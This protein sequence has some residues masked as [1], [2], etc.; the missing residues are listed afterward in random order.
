MPRV[1]I[2]GF[3][4]SAIATRPFARLVALLE[5]FDR[6]RLDLLPVLTYHR[7]DERAGDGGVGSGVFSAT[8][9]EFS[10]Q[11]AWLAVHRRI[12]S[13]SELLDVRRGRT[14][15]P[16]RSI[17]VTFDD[18]YRD[19]ADAA[20]PVLKERGVPVTL[21]VPTA[22]PGFDG[23][24]FWWDKLH[25]A[26]A[27]TARRDEIET[28]FGRLPLRTTDD[29]A[30]ALRAVRTRIRAMAH[31]AALKMLDDIVAQLGVSPAVSPVL[32][33]PE[34]RILAG[35]GV[36]LA[37]HSRTHP[38]LDRVGH[39]VARAEIAGSLCD[40]EREV[41]SAPRVFAYPGG[42][43]TAEV[44]SLV[45]EAG[46]E[47]AFTTQRGMNDLRR[48]DWLRL[49]RINVGRRSTVPLMR[50]QLLSWSRHLSGADGGRP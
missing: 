16:R 32:S 28:P 40:L 5:R 6:S 21:F 46:F 15:L 3:A 47:L 39:D 24:A 38:L 2:R 35:Q 29:R 13:L 11:V 48:A 30:R 36:A 27:T 50:A 34:L 4:S 10:A 41:G 43:Y 8:P 45:A 9:R 1:A 22:Y 49:R 33:W 26:F 7:I 42:A 20:W 37:P 19:F 23:R 44:V 17:M 25:D 14:P 12:L 31:E 18:A